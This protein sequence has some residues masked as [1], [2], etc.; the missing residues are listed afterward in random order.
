MARGSYS[1]ICRCVPRT[2]RVCVLVLLAGPLPAQTGSSK[3][4][5][6]SAERAAAVKAV[7]DYALNYTKGLPNYTCSLTTREVASPTNAGNKIDPVMTKIEEQLSFVNGKEI[8]KV[9][10]ID[11]RPVSPETAANQLKETTTGEFGSLLDVIFEPATG[12]NLRW[13]RVATLNKRRVDVIAFQVPQS[14]GYVLNASSGSVRVPFEGFVYAD[15]QTHEV[16]RVQMKCLMVPEK[17][18]MQNFDL[19]L[20]YKAAQVA[21][22]EVILPAHFALSYRDY[23]DDRLHT[24]D[25]QYSAYLQFSANATIQ[26]GGDKQ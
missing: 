14:R 26:F 6:S 19:T 1:A 17:F 22:H 12:A 25:G 9:M 18:A 23:V 3:G 10:R 21:G 20:D 13:D 2:L 16:L 5:L 15:A 4:G 7:Q 8:R 11:G 24:D